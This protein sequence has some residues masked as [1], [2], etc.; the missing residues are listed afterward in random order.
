MNNSFNFQISKTLN[1]KLQL[2]SKLSFILLI[3]RTEILILVEL[4][5]QFSQIFSNKKKLS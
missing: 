4:Y 5:I 2:A 1:L 3:G